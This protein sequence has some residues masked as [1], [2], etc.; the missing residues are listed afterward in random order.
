MKDSCLVP[1]ELFPAMAE[2]LV[3]LR[4]KKDAGTITPKETESLEMVYTLVTILV[5]G[6]LEVLENKK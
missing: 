1:I 4:G 6:S 3:N 2:Q 5:R